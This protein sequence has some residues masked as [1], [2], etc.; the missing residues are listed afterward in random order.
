MVPHVA[1]Q[2]WKMRV[3]NGSRALTG[4]LFMTSTR[5]VSIER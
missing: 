3:E 5:A 2:P 4:R 1:G